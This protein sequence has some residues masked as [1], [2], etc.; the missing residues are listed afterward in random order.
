M[1]RKRKITVDPGRSE[2]TIQ[3]TKGQSLAEEIPYVQ[4]HPKTG[5]LS[6]RR[7]YAPPLRPFIAK[8]NVELKRS[9]GTS[10][11]LAPGAWARYCEAAAEYDRIVAAAARHMEDS[12][13]LALGITTALTPEII[14]NLAQSYRSEELGADD[15]YRWI[16][17]PAADKYRFLHQVRVDRETMRLECLKLRAAGDL[18]GMMAGYGY[19]ATEFASRHAMVI[20]S[21]DPLFAQYCRAIVDAIIDVC[22]AVIT[23]SEG[24]A[25]PT[26]IPP[27]EIVPAATKRA[28]LR[29][30]FEQIAEDILEKSVPAVGHSTK[31]GARTAL[32]FFRETYGP[33]VPED[34]TRLMVTEWIRLLAK[35]PSRLPAADRATPLPLLVEQYEGREGVT[36]LSQQTLSQHVGHLG[37]LWTKAQAEDGVIPEA[38]SNPFTNRR[39]QVKAAPEEPIEFSKA[40]L[41]ATF[42][43]PIFTAGERP[44]RGKGEA[45][46]WLP[47]LVLSIGARPEE[48]AQ[49]M[50]D[51]IFQDP[52]D[53][54]GAWLLRITDEGTHPHK[55]K[56]SLKTEKSSSGR[57]TFVIPKP[58]LD[59]NFLAYVEYLREADETALFPALRTKGARGYLYAAFAEWWS[60][61]LRANNVLPE[62]GG[63]RPLR[64]FR[65]NW[66]SA[67]RAAG[68]PED[69]R[70]YLMGHSSSRESANARY[71]SHRAHGRW[72]DKVRFPAVEWSKILPWAPPG[73]V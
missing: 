72:M 21:D 70:K 48:V 33:V 26:P 1:A 23:R 41:E 18:E 40:E 38:L 10:S 31:E 3:G 59:L 52:E 16:D 58:L 8:P 17:R 57:R 51:D 11:I 4:A 62:G 2:G 28:P 71:G 37:A 15:E 24:I 6:Y 34:I 47:L 67:A 5:R 42:A 55:G 45:S 29:L 61:Y 30:T 9:L 49:L 27:A 68:V 65:H 14:E 60:L 20:R 73:N 25:A 54:E 53:P 19:T 66:S 64:E 7:V 35:R 44:Q 32:R 63:R 43:L 39:F 36:R 69:A 12:A 13:K 22:Q 56:R 46:Y 50:V